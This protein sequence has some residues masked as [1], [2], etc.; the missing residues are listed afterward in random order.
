MQ[1][2]HNFGVQRNIPEI[3][4]L[5]VCETTESTRTHTLRLAELTINRRKSGF[6]I[7]RRLDSRFGRLH[8]FPVRLDPRLYSPNLASF[9]VSLWFIQRQRQRPPIYRTR[10][11]RGAVLHVPGLSRKGKQYRHQQQQHHESRCLAGTEQRL[12]QIRATTPQQSECAQEEDH[13]RNRQK[14]RSRHT[15][16][17]TRQVRLPTASTA[18]VRRPPSAILFCSSS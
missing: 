15:Q 4:H 2:K 1:F 6:G 7:D 11:V 9:V 16:I 5:L 10:L 3:A 14:P 13:T 12:A 18:A 8:V 17:Y